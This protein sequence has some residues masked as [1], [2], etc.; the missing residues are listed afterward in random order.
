M[1]QLQRAKVYRN[2]ELRQQW[3]G[4]EPFDAL[5]VGGLA[6]ALMLFNR[7]AAGWN[8]LVVV[9]GYLAI[10]LGK[11]G[12]PEG[13]T[14]SLVRFYTRKPFFSAGA[15][16]TRACVFPISRAPRAAD[17]APRARSKKA[18]TSTPGWSR[19]DSDPQHIPQPQHQGD[20][21]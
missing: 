13:Y 14:R 12:K 19:R 10:R 18:S 2:V 17:G 16:D 6:W 8:V 11:R 21:P 15:R 5:A 20:T 9:V 4:L 3:L 1:A 7:D